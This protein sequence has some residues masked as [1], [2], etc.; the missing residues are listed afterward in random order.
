MTGL[1][2]A[3]SV[4]GLAG[5]LVILSQPVNSDTAMFVYMGKLV[6][7]GGRVGVDLIDNKLPTVGLLMSLPHAL[8]GSAWW[9]YGLLGLAMTIV[10]SLML[11]RTARRCLGE[12]AAVP[13]GL[14]AALWLNFP[15]LV[16]GHLQL[17]TIEILFTTLAGCAAMELIARRDWRDAI[18][19]GLCTGL[20]MWAKPTAG[21]VVP[22]A[23]GA[24]IFGTTWTWRQ[25]LSTVGMIA[26]GGLLPSLVCVWLLWSLGMIEPLPAIFE[27]LRDYA[28]HSTAK[29][30][31]VIKPVL[32]LAALMFPVAVWG[33]VFRRD[34]IASQ[35]NRGL[36]FFVV[37]WLVME[38]VAVV[39]QR[40]MYA[41]HF[42]VMA[43]P[44]S[45]VLGLFLR[46]A[47]LASIGF[48]LGP[49]AALSAVFTY[50]M[51]TFPERAL[52]MNSVI[53]WLDVHAKS[54]DAVWMDDYA[55]LM[56][57]TDFR[58]G[59]RVPLT[60]LFGN[61]DA[62]PVHFG[63]IILDDLQTR[64]PEWVVLYHDV[65][66]Y[67]DFY[68]HHMVEIAEFPE[69]GRNFEKA[70]RDIDGYVRANYVVAEQVDGMDI[71]RRADTTAHAVD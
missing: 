5:R 41:Y 55:Q 57:E 71:L 17:E 43:P 61:S 44:A 26:I 35:R 46:K 38:T 20:A 54:Q 68:R 49:V 6:S 40:R 53:A 10:A 70:W 52:R 36:A 63:S 3:I 59:S 23:I 16:Y 29:W 32:V 12:S 11:A 47:R 24:I 25:R 56:V 13:V 19:I 28:N 45:L 14:A 67:V 18:V 2:I 27:Q 7:E 66:T 50:Q 48:A 62:A 65:G 30:A 22:A 69:R 21:A 60:F 39:M 42:L 34:A 15:P 1:V 58:P 9:A 4:I 51:L 64:Q 37:G 8:L 31:D 33:Y